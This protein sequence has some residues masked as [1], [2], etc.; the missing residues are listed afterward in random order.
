MAAAQACAPRR[1][2]IETGRG[3]APR[4]ERSLE[5]QQRAGERDARAVDEVAARDAAV[6]AEGA[7]GWAHE[8]DSW[9]RPGSAHY[10]GA[11]HGP[12]GSGRVDAAQNG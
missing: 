7:V 3:T 2:R 4:S 11:L 12:R 5:G 6:H 8:S 1:V 10:T 9:S